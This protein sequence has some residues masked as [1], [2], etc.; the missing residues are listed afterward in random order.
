MFLFALPLQD[1]LTFDDVRHGWHQDFLAF[2]R[3]DLPAIVFILAYAF[4][5][6]RIVLFFVN[7]IRGLADHQAAANPQRASELRTVAAVLRASAYGVIGFIVLVH[8]LDVIGIKTTSLL[9]SAGV[10]GV[11]IGLGAQSLFKDV[12]NGIFILIENQYNVG[13]TVKIASLT[14]TVEDITL[15]LT[16]LRD[17]DGALYFIP[18]S[19]VATVANHSRDFAIAT[20]PIVVDAS[21]DPDKVLTLL[22]TT[23]LAVRNE[24]AFKDAAA[25]DPIVPGIDC[26]AGRAV[27]YPISI[28]VAVNQKDAI[29]R[30]LRRRILL[31]FEESSIPLGTDPANLFVAPHPDPTAPPARQPLTGS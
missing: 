10:V 4:I 25:A 8:V 14:G 6:L 11:G 23:A 31:A 28:R 13:D 5:L 27:T 30:E 15:R 22:R 1:D 19:Q 24:P 20:L 21:A 29:L 17:T 18:N 26:I 9:A 2:I 3:H 16:T 7:R 12:L